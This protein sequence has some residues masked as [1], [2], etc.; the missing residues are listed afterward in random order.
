[1]TPEALHIQGRNDS[2]YPYVKIKF[3]L[4]KMYLH[5]A[6]QYILITRIFGSGI[7]NFLIVLIR[8]NAYALFPSKQW[9]PP[10]WILTS[11]CML[12]CFCLHDPMLKLGKRATE[13]IKRKLLY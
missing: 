11:A 4:I 13:F 1:M 5:H 6:S 7:T 3:S 10:L 2:T 9:V 12:S 8:W